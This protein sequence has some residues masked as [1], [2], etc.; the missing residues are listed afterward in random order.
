[1]GDQAGKELNPVALEVSLPKASMYWDTGVP[2]D[3]TV[4]CVGLIQV[5]VAPLAAVTLDKPQTASPLT[6]IKE[7]VEA[8]PEVNDNAFFTGS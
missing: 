4:D 3:V 1:M 7:L 5:E 6:L 2:E 8:V